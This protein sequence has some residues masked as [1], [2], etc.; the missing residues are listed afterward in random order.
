[1]LCIYINAYSAYGTYSQVLQ[2]FWTFVMTL[3]LSMNCWKAQ[4]LIVMLLTSKKY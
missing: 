3:R 1:M 2:V 4:K